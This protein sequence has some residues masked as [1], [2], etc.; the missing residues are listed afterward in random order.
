MSVKVDFIY[1]IASPNVYLAHKLIPDIEARTGV[2]FNYVPTLLG[3][4]FKAT[5]NQPPFITFANVKGRFAYEQLEF[6]RFLKRH[7]LS[8]FKMNSNFPVHTVLLQRGALVAQEL[9]VFPAYFEAGLKAVWEDNLNPK[10]PD[11]LAKILNKAGLDAATIIERA[12]SPEIKA[13]LIQ[14]TDEAANRGTFG[15]PTFFVGEEMFFGKDRLD[16]VE[17]EIKAQQTA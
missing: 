12:Q 7:K 14:N 10:E 5:G 4:I 6:Q 1:D 16:Q 13:K 17:E 15:A 3:G 2:K 11:V 8:K 9:G